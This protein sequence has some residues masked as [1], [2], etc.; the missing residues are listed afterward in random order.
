MPARGA[1]GSE[2]AHRRPAELGSGVLG[3]KA[4]L[5]IAHCLTV[6]FHCGEPAH[7]QV[8]VAPWLERQIAQARHSTDSSCEGSFLIIRRQIDPQHE[9]YCRALDA[10]WELC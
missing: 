5:N 4:F 8:S 10:A 2:T 9:R 7:Q 3:R 6:F 1:D